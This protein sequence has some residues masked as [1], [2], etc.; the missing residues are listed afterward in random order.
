MSLVKKRYHSFI[1]R[2][3]CTGYLL[4][5]IMISCFLCDFQNLLQMNKAYLNV[6]TTNYGFLSMVLLKKIKS[7]EKDENSVPQQL[8]AIPSLT[9]LVK[10]LEETCTYC[11]RVKKLNSIYS[12]TDNVFQKYKKIKQLSSEVYYLHY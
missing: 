3:I 4:L 2:F 10:L 12:K 8:H 7:K 5:E 6:R 11:L 1:S 9:G